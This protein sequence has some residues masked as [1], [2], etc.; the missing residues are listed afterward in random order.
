M[1][2]LIL[3]FLLLS[4]QASA[5]LKWRNVDSAFAPLPPSVHVFFTDDRV[6]TGRFRAYYLVADLEDKALDF[7]ADTSRGRRLTP[8]EFYARDGKPLVVVNT[9][10][11][12]FE[13]NSNLNVV[14]RKGKLLA[15]NRQDY[16]GRGR[17]TLT[18]RH[19][20]PAALGIDRKR[21]AR[22]MWTFTDSS[23]RKPY[24]TAVGDRMP[25]KDSNRTET[26]DHAVDRTRIVMPHQ[27]GSYATLKK[28]KV[29]TAVG[30]G[31]ALLMDG[32]LKVTNDEEWRF[33][34]K[35][36][37]DKHPRT[38]MGITADGKLI[39]LVVEGRNPEAS[40]ATLTQEAE[41]L[42]DL[43][44]REGINLDGGGSSCLLINGKETIRPSDK[45]QRSV[46][47]VFEIRLR[48]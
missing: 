15:Y 34:G 39:I 36:I 29:R 45:V 4:M 41:I 26:L 37:N 13:T 22:V 46:P 28:W 2:T 43:G 24:A 6:D 23:R 7:V 16:A 40:G 47:G 12:S 9:T 20:L 42:R 25:L 33:P 11:F 8:S 38:A 3:I 44:C 5:Q 48:K 30:G 21:R 32:K 35:A 27:G 1:R 18:Y 17:D 19:V 31:P 14:V 10:F